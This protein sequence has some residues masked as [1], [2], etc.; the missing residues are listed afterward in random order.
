MAI[1]GSMNYNYSMKNIPQAPKKVVE[2]ML[3]SSMES[4]INR[5]RW[6]LFWYKS[7]ITNNNRKETFEGEHGE[8]VQEEE[9]DVPQQ[10]VHQEAEGNQVHQDGLHLHGGTDSL[11]GQLRKSRRI[12]QTKYESLAGME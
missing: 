3:V 2:K 4:L 1:T 10:Q 9:D 8:L 7:P 6:K 5:M 12:R 11:V